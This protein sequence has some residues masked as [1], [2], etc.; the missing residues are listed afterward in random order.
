[1]KLRIFWLSLLS[2][3]G[4]IAVLNAQEGAPSSI[5][6]QDNISPLELQMVFKGFSSRKP[7]VM[8]GDLYLFYH[9]HLPVRYVS[10]AFDF[11]GYTKQYLMY[12]GEGDIFY[13][14]VTPPL[15]YK[16][17]KYR[18]VVDGLWTHDENNSDFQENFLGNKFS[19]LSLPDWNTTFA[20]QNPVITDQGR[21]ILYYLGSSGQTVSVAGN[22][23]NWNPFINQLKEESDRPGVY[24]IEL[25]IPPGDVYYYFVVAG[26]RYLD[27]L[28][29]ARSKASFLRPLEGSEGYNVSFFH[30]QI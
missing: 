22:F 30:R 21:V 20:L 13:V 2:L 25:D 29:P 12:R 9:S 19:L 3:V 7:I 15:G 10:V 23:N 14:K 5:V 6:I 26:N 1:V 18:Y 28:N 24:S 4:F 11:D 16:K 27:T 17:V 8:G